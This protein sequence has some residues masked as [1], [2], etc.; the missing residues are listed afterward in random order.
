MKLH[1]KFLVPCVN[2]LYAEPRC[3]VK[4]T[5]VRSH[6]ELALLWLREK[7]RISHNY[8]YQI[9]KQPNEIG[10]WRQVAWLSSC[11]VT[12]CIYVAK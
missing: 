5:I 7:P 4:T 10:A 2:A 12:V 8:E 6:A 1:D 11:T 3:S 9:K